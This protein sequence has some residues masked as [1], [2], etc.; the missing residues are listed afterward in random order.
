MSS[1]P[2][3]LVLFGA[4]AFDLL[5]DLGE[6][7]AEEHRQDRRRRFV[8]AEAMIVAGVRDAVAQQALPDVDRA[9]H[10][11][12]EEQELHVVVRRVARVQQVVA[13]VVAD[14]PVQVLAGAVDA[15]KRLLVHQ[16]RQAV[17]RRHPLHRLH[18]HHLVIGGDVG[19][20]ED[21][22]DFVLRRRDFVVARL[23]RHADTCR[24]RIRHSAMNASTRSGIDPK[25]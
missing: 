3:L 12:A 5:E 8:G 17:L 23:D 21:R 22:R 7:V 13:E 19:A 20:L 2:P 6:H 24:A 1:M 16:A 14:A 10:R 15:G 9:N 4:A 18:R 11:R 25:Y